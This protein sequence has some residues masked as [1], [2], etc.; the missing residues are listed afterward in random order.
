MPKG[1]S[2]IAVGG[3]MHETNTFSPVPTELKHF[4]EPNF[5][6]GLLRGRAVID[7]LS[8]R[9]VGT[10]GAIEVLD[11]AGCEIVPTVWAVATPSGL[12]TRHAFETV[13]GEIVGGITAAGRLD[14][15]YLELHGAMVTDD[16]E[17]AEGEMLRRVREVVGPAVPIVATLDLHANVSPQMIECADALEAYRTY[18]HVDVGA[19]G[20]RGARCLLGL[21]AQRSPWYKAH[22]RLGYLVPTPWQTTET[23]PS[24]GIYAALEASLDERV[25]TMS[26]TPGFNAGDVPFLSPVV[27]AYGRDAQAVEAAAEGVYAKLVAAET[28][29]S[30]AIYDA[31]AVVA[32]ALRRSAGPIVI[33]DAEDNPGGGGAGD[34]TAI[35]AAL[36]AQRAEGAVVAAI[37]DARAIERAQVAGEGAAIEIELGG[38]SDGR[39]FAG[40]FIV[41]RLGNG[42]FDAT[43]PMFRGAR[44]ALGT[45][46]LLRIDGVR[47]IVIQR[48]NQIADRGIFYHVG[49]EPREQRIIV[50]KSI[51][52]FRNDF[53]AIA[54]DILIAAAGGAV[55][56]DP[57]T[58]PFRRLDPALRLFPVRAAT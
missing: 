58:L 50:V 9:N 44:T 14:G 6:P 31:D 3:F 16:L 53:Q 4:E 10:A 23:E 56:I 18:P 17:D 35:L 28:L 15:V 29:F 39:P 30:G 47:V 20:A 32:E 41:E 40:R 38:A 33:A 12:V 21:I 8:G 27:L 46:A 49:L 26:F 22:R 19:T 24:R 2:R 36:V 45:L 37:A 13:A 57:R 54:A 52:H 34:T 11:A 5:W 42:T 7:E 43:G 25:T 1:K 51:V 48:P 55:P